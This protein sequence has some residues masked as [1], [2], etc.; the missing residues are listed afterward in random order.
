MTPGEL[1]RSTR[2]AHGLTQAEVAR[3]ARTSQPVI[4]AYE[5]N[6]RDPTLGTLRRLIAAGGGRLRLD[7]ATDAGPWSTGRP[8][9]ARPSFRRRA[10][11]R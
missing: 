10:L 11:A 8:R 4:S 6:R 2:M 1:L 7:H 9:G 5:H 3:R